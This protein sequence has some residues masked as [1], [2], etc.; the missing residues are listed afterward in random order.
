M[1][2]SFI[3]GFH[4]ARRENLLQTL[5]FLDRWH[6]CT[7]QECELITVCQDKLNFDIPSHMWMRHK[8]FD[9]DLTE[10]SL[11]IVTNFGVEQAEFEKLVILESDRI[12]PAGYFS[13]ILEQLECGVQIT[14]LKMKKLKQECT[15][16]L[17]CSGEFDFFDE[18]RSPEN[19][20]GR[21]NMWSGNTALMKSDFVKAGKMDESYI[22][23]GW[24]DSDM[25]LTM[26]KAG[27]KSVYREEIELHLWHPPL[28]YGTKDQKKLFI[29]NGLRLCQK[30]NKPL[31]QILRQ[32]MAQHRTVEI[33]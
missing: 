9:L 29:N 8:H 7:I 18:F 27:V 20:F 32:E 1:S 31:P 15:D 4:T 14:T 13:E 25:C 19:E 30:W 21:R 3:I 12:L 22:G 16:E 2:A 5:R 17:I 11:P 23:Y 33:I 10:M 24:A 28:T 6:F 26:E